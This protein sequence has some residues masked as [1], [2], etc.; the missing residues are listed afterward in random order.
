MSFMPIDSIVVDRQL[1]PDDNV[2]VLAKSI[3]DQGLKFPVLI[4]EDG[5]LVDGLRRLEASRLAGFTT[6]QVVI[7]K[8][9]EDATEALAASHADTPKKRLDYPPWRLDQIW[10]TALKLPH[11]ASW[12]V[13]EHPA[14]TLMKEALHLSSEN[15]LQCTVFTYKMAEKPGPEGDIAREAVQ[16]MEAGKI[17][18]YGGRIRIH[19]YRRHV[20][21]A[22][23][24][25]TKAQAN[26]IIT[27]AVANILGTLRGFDLVPKGLEAEAFDLKAIKKLA[28]ELEEARTRLVDMAGRFRKIIKSE[29]THE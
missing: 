29:E 5:V 22:D 23:A 6:V 27:Q 13:N 24:T 26:R 10:R 19:E 3:L 11:R 9:F 2:E 8:T 12:P 21:I 20:S 18:G 15:I 25:M 14:R 1:R 16:L 17:N 4:R 28:Y 7:A